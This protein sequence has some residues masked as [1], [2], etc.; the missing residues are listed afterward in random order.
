VSVEAVERTAPFETRVAVGVGTGLLGFSFTV[1]GLLFLVWARL[2]GFVVVVFL[3]PILLAA[4]WPAFVRQARR[5][6]DAR[7][8]RLLLLALALKLVG[9]LVRYWVA[10]HIYQGNADAFEYH[11]FGVDL[12]MRFRAGN[13]DT[14]LASLSGT[15]FISFVTGIVYTITGPSIFAGFLLYAWLA[16]GGMFYLYRAFTI[17]IPD[18]N[19][20]GYARLLFFM[21]SMLY[22]PSSIGKE[23]WMLLTLGLAAYGTARLLT[24]R[25]W[26]GLAVTGLALWLAAIV[27]AH[28]SGMAVLG[29]VVA[30]LIARPPRRLGALGPVVKLFALVALVVVAGGL[31][32]RTQSYLLEKGIDPQDGVNSVLAET[33]R[34]TDQGGS[35]FEAPSTGTSLARIPFAAI[36]ILFRPFPFEA[37]NVQAG[38][39]AL[40]STLLL[41]LTVARRRAIWQAIRHLRKRPYV[42]FVLVYSVL[43]V[44]AFS[45]IANFGILARERTQLL[46]FFLVLLAV[47][48]A[49]RRRRVPAPAP[50]QERRVDADRQLVRA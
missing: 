1:I 32:S 44:I 29:L 18:G 9:S 14:G 17:A 46:P 19:R 8:V 41:C 48:P 5:E 13:F 6:R 34:R 37:H 45:S 49:A 42:A 3:V 2:D 31:L 35:N 21:P 36:T 16:F 26:R 33:T 10:V 15:D 28:V 20:R 38:V 23:A 24:G 30:Y 4:S 50:S 39:T 27:R 47:P 11:R 40:E 7:L 22:W 43:F 12:A 25:P